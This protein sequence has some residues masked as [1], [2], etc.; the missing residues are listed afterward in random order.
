MEAKD[1]ALESSGVSRLCVGWGLALQVVPRTGMETLG[2]CCGTLNPCALPQPALSHLHPGSQSDGT[3]EGI[4]C[5]GIPCQTVF[6]GSLLPQTLFL[7]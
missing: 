5:S 6:N 3:F 4:I 7:C 2:D 1:K